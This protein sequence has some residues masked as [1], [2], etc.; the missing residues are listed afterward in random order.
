LKIELANCRGQKAIPA[1]WG[2]NANGLPTI[3]PTIVL[4]PG[5]GLLPL[6]GVEECGAYKGTGIAMMVAI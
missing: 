4:A 2:A 3:D 6:G 1:T 5:G